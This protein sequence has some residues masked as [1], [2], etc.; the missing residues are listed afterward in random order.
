MSDYFG[1]LTGRMERFR[2][3]ILNSKPY[4]CAERAVLTTNSYKENLNKPVVLKRAYMLKDILENMSIF[5]E[6]DTL[7]VGNQASQN[8]SAP[9]FP[10]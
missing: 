5:I 6:K 1:K 4:V 9:I 3:E 7:I 10:E 2:E 8:R